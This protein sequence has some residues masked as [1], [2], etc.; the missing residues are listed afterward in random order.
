MNIQYQTSG[1]CS[2]AINVEIENN[3]VKSVEYIGGC[4]G[5]LKGIASLVKGMPVEEVIKRLKGIRCGDK[6]TSC[7]DQLVKCLEKYFAEI[8]EAVKK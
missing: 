6:T 3:V 4:D 7:P 2:A 1:T 8:K 5:N